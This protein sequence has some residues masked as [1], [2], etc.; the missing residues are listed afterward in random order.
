MLLE[1]PLKR[2]DRRKVGGFFALLVFCA[3]VVG[4]IV[5]LSY[6][7]NSL[8]LSLLFV[9]GIG[10]LMMFLAISG[11]ENFRQIWGFVA[12]AMIPLALTGDVE[13]GPF[14][15]SFGILVYM[16]NTLII[17]ADKVSGYTRANEKRSVFSKPLR[18][19][20]I[21]TVLSTLLSAFR[22]Y[23]FVDLAYF[24][25]AS[26]TFV[27]IRRYFNT[28]EQQL[29]LIKLFAFVSI[30]IL[31]IATAEHLKQGNYNAL[32]TG[33]KPFE[34]LGDER[35]RVNGIF[36]NANSYGFFAGAASLFFGGLSL[37]F[38]KR[39][40]RLW[41]YISA[42]IFV[43]GAATLWFCQSRGAFIAYLAALLFL[44]LAAPPPKKRFGIWVVVIP[45]MVGAIAW[46]FLF[47]DTGSRL[48]NLSALTTRSIQIAT[49]EDVKEQMNLI[50]TLARPILWIIGFK[51]WQAN[52][53]LGIG[54]SNTIH[55]IGPYLPPMLR[56]IQGI[57][58]HFHSIYLNILYEG[59]LL[60][61]GA[62]LWFLGKLISHVFGGLRHRGYFTGY[63]SLALGAVW[64]HLF[65]HG[66]VDTT[67]AMGQHYA[68]AGIF[69]L[70]LAFQAFVAD[71]VKRRRHIAKLR[72]E[73]ASD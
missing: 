67:F 41:T 9:L 54:H 65:A 58:F 27:F 14:D 12:V 23:G 51:L 29:K 6:Y 42:G 5:Y 34:G 22:F 3:L 44:V 11:L 53:L 55:Y 21:L 66:L 1:N 52:P 26:S 7:Q 24:L 50:A 19:L 13:F 46:L 37:Y 68:E 56:P 30:Y 61:F 25:L 18:L 4:G 8:F 60:S 20:L 73:R 64:V 2:L 35:F 16:I 72:R 48:T 47:S 69:F 10:G 39:R 36:H 62:F 45:L 40:Q 63:A 28:K 31:L 71:R 43:W 59:G 70:F 38:H 17:L 32:L 33:F 49:A 15:A 57:L